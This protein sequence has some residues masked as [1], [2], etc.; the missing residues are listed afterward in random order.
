MLYVEVLNMIIEVK[1]V[2]VIMME[3]YAEYFHPG[4]IMSTLWGDNYKISRK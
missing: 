2:K 1:S 3:I 4:C